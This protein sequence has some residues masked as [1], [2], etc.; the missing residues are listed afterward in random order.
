M[1]IPTFNRERF[2]AEAIDSV[3]NQTLSELELIVVDDGS[4]DSTP[5]LV[6]AIHD[7][8]LRY[9]AQSNR[10]LSAALNRGL[11]NSRAE[12]IARL[13]SDDIFLADALAVMMAAIQTQPSDTIVWARG[14]LMDA[15]GRLQPR[16]RGSREH[17]SGE[18]LRSLLYEDCTTSPAML[19]PRS[20]YA[21]VGPYDETLGAGEDWDMALRLARHFPFH[22][23]DRIVVRIRE[24]DGAMTARNSPKLVEFLNTRNEPLDK[25][26]SDPQLPANMLALRP[27]AYT[28]LYIFRGRMWIYARNFRN[29]AREL[30]RAMVTTDTPAKTAL[31]IVWR[32]IIVQMF[33]RTAAG[34]RVLQRINAPEGSSAVVPN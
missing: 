8:R 19:I 28:N 26:F 11:E 22:F 10:G 9:I 7:D 4:T 23:V 2:L 34:R 13:D 25:L 3:L 32:V 5:E 21:R 30:Y 16:T 15:H 31:A 29:A 14:Q 33:D 24:H 17:F 27:F 6:N 1:V 12:Y 18:M 20:C